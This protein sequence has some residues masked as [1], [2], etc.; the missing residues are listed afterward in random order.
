MIV[1]LSPCRYFLKLLIVPIVE[2]NIIN[3][4]YASIPS[5]QLFNGTATIISPGAT[6]LHFRF[7]RSGAP[8]VTCPRTWHAFY[9]ASASFLHLLLLYTNI[10]SFTV[11]PLSPLMCLEHQ[12][13]VE[14]DGAD[15]ARRIWF[16]YRLICSSTF[17]RRCWVLL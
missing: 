8:L 9:I 14:G 10:Q 4:I 1:P 11:S 17:K 5:V 13:W 12:Q 7:H 16:C 2:E 3:H 15:Y 6:S